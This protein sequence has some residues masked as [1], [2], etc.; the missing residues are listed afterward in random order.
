MN[1]PHILI[2]GNPID[3]FNYIGPFPSYE[4]A[5]EYCQSD[6]IARNE[7]W[8]IFELEQPNRNGL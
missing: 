4:D 1:T 3:G 8:W 2:L 6:A 5:D 7:S